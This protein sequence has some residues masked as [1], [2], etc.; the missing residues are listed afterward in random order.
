MKEST[1]PAGA[2]GNARFD[3]IYRDHYRAI[4]AYCRRRTHPNRVDDAVA[5]V[6]TIAWRR[7]HDV[8]PGDGARPWLYGVAYRV[9]ANQ[10]RGERRRA[11]F[12]RRLE[13]HP[14]AVLDGPQ[15]QIVKKAE[16][17]LVLRAMHRL[18]PIEQ[19][20]LRLSVWEELPQSQIARVLGL[21][22]GA[23]K[24]RLHRARK[25]LSRE[26]ERLNP[27]EQTRLRRGGAL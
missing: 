2:T 27:S 22:E 5:D 19:E 17:E 9:L 12:L 14:P 10:L 20:L 8:P 4:H 7:I 23:V 1:S 18:A 21:T 24:Q 25:K 26:Y 3:A 16:Y 11:I 6:F 13:H 15:L